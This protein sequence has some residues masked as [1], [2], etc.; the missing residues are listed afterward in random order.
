M[1]GEQALAPFLFSLNSR[2]LLRYQRA[3]NGILEKK[4][5]AV[6]VLAFVCSALAEFRPPPT[7]DT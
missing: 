2:L 7:R 6:S 4:K 3:R 1:E 5:T